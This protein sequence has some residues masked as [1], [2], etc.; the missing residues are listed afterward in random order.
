MIQG[1]Y[2]Q[3]GLKAGE[4][5]LLAPVEYTLELET[6]PVRSSMTRDSRTTPAYFLLSHQFP[7]RLIGK[8]AGWLSPRV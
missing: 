2:R 8:L 6:C 1:R 3:G 5:N 7:V 4:R